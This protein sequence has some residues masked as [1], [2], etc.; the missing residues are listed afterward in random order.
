MNERIKQSILRYR[1]HIKA[2]LASNPMQ[3]PYWLDDGFNKEEWNA[4]ANIIAV[5]FMKQI[6][7]GVVS[8]TGDNR[9]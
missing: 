2:V 7:R 9:G 4:D 8:P 5:F 1:K 3:S 6:R